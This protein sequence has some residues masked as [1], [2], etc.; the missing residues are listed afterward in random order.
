LLKTAVVQSLK[1]YCFRCL[2][3]DCNCIKQVHQKLKC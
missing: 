1:E 2:F 3:K